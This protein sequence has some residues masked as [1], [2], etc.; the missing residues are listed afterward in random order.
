MIGTVIN[1]YVIERKLGEGAMGTVYFARH[2]R[3]EREV[4]IKVLHANLFTNTEIRNRF[5]NEANALIKL[6]HLN[7]VK[8]YD[9][10]EQENTACLIMEYIKGHTLDHFISRISGPLPA[11][12]CKLLI[13]SV[14][15]AVQY[16]HDNNILHRDIKPENIMVGADNH[17]SIMD[18]GIAKLTNQ[19]NHNATQANAQLGTPFYM[20]PEQVKGFVFTKLSDIYSLGVTLFEIASG[21][22]PYGNIT[23]LFELQ[24]KIVNEPLP[25]TSVYYPNV[26]QRIQDAIKIATHKNPEQRFQ[27]CNEFIKFLN[28]EEKYQAQIPPLKPVLP[29]KTKFPVGSISLI[30]AIIIVLILVYM[31]FQG[32]VVDKSPPLLILGGSDTTIVTQGSKLQESGDKS[33]DEV[34]GDISNNIEYVMQ[35]TSNLET[36]LNKMGSQLPFDIP[37]NEIGTYRINIT[38]KDHSGNLVHKSRIIIVDD[39]DTTK[40]A[41]SSLAFGGVKVIYIEEGNYFTEADAIAIDVNGDN[42]SGN[43]QY[44]GFVNGVG[45][46]PTRLADK[47]GTYKIYAS[48]KDGMGKMLTAEKTVIVTPKCDGDWSKDLTLDGKAIPEEKLIKVDGYGKWSYTGELTNSSYK[49]GY[50]IIIKNKNNNETLLEIPNLRGTYKFTLKNEKLSLTL[51]TNPSLVFLITK[52]NT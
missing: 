50:N 18:F 31:L 19:S 9:Y 48:I 16:A 3:I 7:I 2:N 45:R 20:S 30:I 8:I 33:I 46:I 22:C 34:D 5:K 38:S 25:E 28:E 29:N 14:L 26:N 11:E 36:V 35:N 24:S 13:C 49:C 42:V 47:V 37:T 39:T 23:N 52:S 44:S 1:N 43:I 4:A 27:S 32:S 10:V 40:L 51:S 6:N 15:N 41:A 21:K 12:K 17:I